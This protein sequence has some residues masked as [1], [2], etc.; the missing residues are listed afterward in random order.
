MS[1]PFVGPRAAPTAVDLAVVLAVDISHSMDEVEQ[2]LQR[3]GYAAAFRD[4]AV[5]AAIRG[6]LLGRIAVSYVEWST[7]YFQL[8]VVPWTIVDTETSAAAF[9]AEL[10]AEPTN[11]GLETSISGG[12]L[13]AAAHFGRSGV[14]ATRRVI[15]VSGDGPNDSGVPVEAARDRVVAEG[16]TI[17]GLPI[18]LPAPHVRDPFTLADLDAYFHDCVVGGPRSFTVTVGGAD[19]FAEAIRR[20]LILEIADAGP[21]EPASRFSRAAATDCMIGEKRRAAAE[22]LLR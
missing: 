21:A 22:T 20:K 4:P 16:I 13:F 7:R 18:L 11:R 1:A 10:L 8:V 14:S 9:A 5:V 15:D 17:N 19:Q 2:R 12:L 6:G 3:E